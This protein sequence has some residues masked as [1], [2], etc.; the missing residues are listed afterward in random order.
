M[1]RAEAGDLRIAVQLVEAA[2]DRMVLR[3]VDDLAIGK[4]LLHLGGEVFPLDR[5]VEVVEEGRAAAQEELAQG[6]GLGSVDSTRLPGST[7]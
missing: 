7:M 5:A 4:H 2:E 3:E 1:K 6:R